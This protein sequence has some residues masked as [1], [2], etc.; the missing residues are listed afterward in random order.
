[1]IIRMNRFASALNRNQAV[2]ASQQ[3][4]ESAIDLGVAANLIA[5]AKHLNLNRNMKP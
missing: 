5:A 1:M 3:A 2:H 4:I